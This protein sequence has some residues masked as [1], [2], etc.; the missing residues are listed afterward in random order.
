MRVRLRVRDNAVVPPL[1]ST[2]LCGEVNQRQPHQMRV[3][4]AYRDE[5]CRPNLP[6]RLY[7]RPDAPLP[8][9][10]GADCA[11]LLPGPATTHSRSPG[12]PEVVQDEP[13]TGAAGGKGQGILMVACPRRRPHQ[14]R[15]HGEEGAGI[16]YILEYYLLHADDL[17]RGVSVCRAAKSLRAFTQL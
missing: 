4:D 8:A 5:G 3:A 2:G 10:M 16:F 1:P 9:S 15:H 12:C 17:S 11:V 6:V 7:P 14:A 13:S